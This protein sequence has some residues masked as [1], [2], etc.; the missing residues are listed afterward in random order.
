[1]KKA[2]TGGQIADWFAIGTKSAKQ[3]AESEIRES[4]GE[5]NAR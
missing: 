1:M 4:N 3:N 2:V 5:A